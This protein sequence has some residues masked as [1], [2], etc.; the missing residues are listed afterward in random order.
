MAHVAC[1]K[2]QLGLPWKKPTSSNNQIW[3]NGIR[4]GGKVGLEVDYRCAKA[5]V[6]DQL[7]KFV[8]LPPS[9]RESRCPALRNELRRH[10]T[11]FNDFT[12]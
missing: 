3:M 12:N 6:V 7:G 2:G 10:D 11:Q 8:C 4:R 9:L 1:E 5:F